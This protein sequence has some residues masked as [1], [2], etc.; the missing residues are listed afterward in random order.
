MKNLSILLLSSLLLTGCAGTKI[1]DIISAPAPIVIQHPPPPRGVIM[2]KVEW[3]VLNAEILQKMLENGDD[4]Q[5][6]ALTPTGYENLSL[7]MSEIKRYIKQ[8][9]QIIIYYQSITDGAEVDTPEGKK[10]K[11]KD[12]L[13]AKSEVTPDVSLVSLVDLG[14]LTSE[15][16]SSRSTE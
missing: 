12:L 3:R 10:W 14:Y 8:Q 11:F 6:I 7:N 2:R 15:Y 4:V 13:P 5:F 1:L 9:K 16:V